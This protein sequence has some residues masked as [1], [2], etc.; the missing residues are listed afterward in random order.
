MPGWAWVL[1]AVALFTVAVLLIVKWNQSAPYY[2]PVAPNSEQAETSEGGWPQLIRE[3]NARV[4]RTGMILVV[5]VMVVSC[6]GLIAAPKVRVVQAALWPTVTPT[7]TVTRTPTATR[8]PKPTLA[9]TSTPRI[10]GT[11]ATR[12][13]GTGTPGQHITV[14]PTQTARIIYQ[15][16]GQSIVTQLVNVQQTVV[17][18]QL[19]HIQ[20]TVIVYYTVVVT[21]TE[22][23][24]PTGTPT[25]TPTESL[26]PTPTETPTPGT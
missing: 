9:Y 16:G 25:E 13:P 23:P 12:T 1:I 8:T 7:I 2:K 4:A 14:A 20:Q 19:V 10:T 26:T 5:V 3:R 24:T 22:T 21:P 18:T 11:P 17:V 15:N 6:L